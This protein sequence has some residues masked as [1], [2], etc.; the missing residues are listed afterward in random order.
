MT[1][2][3]TF[4]VLSTSLGLVSLWAGYEKARG[5][6]AFAHGVAQYRILSLSLVRLA[7][8]AIVL[9][10]L[11]FGILLLTGLVPVV[12]AAGAI[13]LFAVFAA[14]LGISLARSNRGPCHCFGASDAETISP[15]AFVRALALLGLAVA[16]LVLAL[17]DP[18]YP[19]GVLPSLLM[20]VA[21]A[22]TT[23]LSS[24]FPLAW[25]FLRTPPALHPT[26]TNRVSFRHQPLDVPLFPEERE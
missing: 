20:A 16:T 23:R 19:P 2:A 1:G 5:L 14:A 15:L 25:S 24:L 12:A 11:G 17:G 8:T 10:E 21:I 7:A 9:A 18:G 4:L 6:D 22:L 13:A 26:A 3:V